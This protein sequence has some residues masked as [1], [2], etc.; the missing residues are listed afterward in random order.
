M[1][2]HVDQL[3]AEMFPPM[4]GSRLLRASCSRCGQVV[5]INHEMAVRCIKQ[6]D[7]VMCRDCSP[8][9]PPSKASVLTPRQVAGLRRTSS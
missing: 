6:E 1:K 3:I 9:Q 4:P 8:D 5:R 2:V 7:V